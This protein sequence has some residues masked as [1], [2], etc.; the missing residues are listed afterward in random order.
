MSAKKSLSEISRQRKQQIAL[1]AEGLCKVCGKPR[2]VYAQLCNACV[3]KRQ[4]REGLKVAS[5]YPGRVGPIPKIVKWRALVEK[6]V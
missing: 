3:V 2:E 1:V 4:K 5:W 6:Q